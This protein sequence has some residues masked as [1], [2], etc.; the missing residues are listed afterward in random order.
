MKGEKLNAIH[1]N[2][3]SDKRERSGRDAE[4]EASRGHGKVQRR[5]GKSRR[6]A[7]RRRVATEFKGSPRTVF[8][9]QADRH[10]WPVYR[11]QGTGRRLLALAGKIPRRSDRMAQALPQPYAGRK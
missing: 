3:Q 10:R 9:K 6:D 11:N 8:G 5:V 1:G 7:G 2:G 4:S